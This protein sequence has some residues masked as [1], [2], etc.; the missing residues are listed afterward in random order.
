MPLNKDIHKVMVIGSGPIIIGQAAEFD[1]A[2]S[3]AC[4]ALKEQGLE[5]VLVNSNPATLMTDHTMADQIYIEPLIP[6][7]I[8]RIIEKEKPDSLL[9]TLGGQ[10]GLTLSMELAKSGFLEKH[11]VKLLG[12][13]PETI[14]KAEDRQMFKDTMLA[15]GEPCIPSKVVTTYEDALDFVKNEIGYPAII[16]PAFTLGGT[17]GGIVHNDEEMDEIAHNG[18]HRSPI[19][20]ILVEKCISGWKE[21]EFEVMRDSAGNVLTVCSMENF[22]PVG[23]HTGDSIVIAPTVTL[24]D[25]EY[26]MLRSAAL[27]IISSLG[28]EGGCNCQ[29][30]LNPNSFEY[31]VIEVN[32][33]VSRSS[34]LASK[35]TG[36]PIAKVATLIAI[37]YTLDEIPN[38]VT[39]KTAACFEPVLD[40]VV[41]KMPKFPFDKFVYA[42]RDLGTQMKATGEVMAIGQ[43]FEQ[44]IMKAVRGAEVG[45]QSLNLPSFVE[46]SDAEIEKRVGEC[47]DQRIFAIFQAIKRN[48]LSIIQIN[49]ITK[50]DLWFL[51]KLENLAFM[52]RDFAKVKAGEKEFTLEFYKAAKNAG[53]PDKVIQELA[54]QKITG[55]SGILSEAK[56]AA[57]L[58][59]QGK[60]AH[61]PAVYKMVDTCAGE[62]NAET[63]YFYG[64]Y[65]FQNEARIFLDERKE[66]GKKSSKGTIIVLG[67]GPIR[68]GQ[69]IEFDYAS[70]QC[71]WALK[72]LGYD[73]VTINNNPETVSTDF[74]TSDRL[75]FEPLTP[76]DVMGVI[77]TEKPVGVVVA[78]GG[79]TAIKLTKFLDSQGIHILGTSADS[80]DLAED[81]E[82]FEELCEK[83]H[84]NRPKGLTIFTEEEALEATQKLGYP[85]LLRPSYVLGGQNMII[86][87]NDDDVKEYMKIILAQGIENPVLIDQYMMGTELEVDAICDGKDILIPGIMEHIERTGIH[88]GD[89]IAVYPSWNLNDILREKIINQSR[90]LALA[91]G[92]KGLVNIQYLIYN[93]DL[94]IIEVNPRSSRTVPYISK[95]TNVPMV[96]LAVRAMLGEKVKDMGFGT[97]LYRLPPYFAVKVPVFSFEKLMDVDTHLG[98]EMKST[99]E[100]LGIASTMEEAI[101]KGLIG[102]GYN[103][104]RSGGV[105]FSVRKTDRY[106]LPDLA[107]K[108]YDMGFKLYATEGNAKTISD[109]GMEVE[110]VNKIHEN[111]NDNL[112]S[113]LDSGKVDYVISTSAKGRDPRA[114]SVR[115]R[116]HAVERDIPC[117]TAIDTAN[118]IANCLK[119]KYT[120]ENVELVDI[121]Q[122]REEKQKITFYK[123]DSTGNDFI[124]IN[125]MNQVVKNPA[126]LAVRLCDRRN[127]GI[128]ADS[129]V[130]IEESKIADAKMRFFNL[131]GTEGKMAGNAI[132]CVGKYLYDN[133]IKGIQEKHGKKTDATEK[134]TIE[135]GSGVKTLVLY[136][137]NGKVTSVTVD[138][139]KPLFAS[140]EIPTSL[141]AVDVPNCGL[142]E[143]IG[144]A[145]LPKKAVVNAPLI[146]AENEYRVTC[147]NVGN[148]H[149]VVFSKFVDKEPVAKIGPLFESHSVFPE[150]TNTE[151]VRVVGPNELKMRTWERGNGETLA[152]GTGACAAAVASVINGFSPINQDIT[153]KVR[154]GNLIVKYTGETVLLTGNTKM[155]YQGEVEI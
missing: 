77:N 101:F 116:R 68:I 127:G 106:E 104:K 124:V 3:Q 110:V 44:A 61:I 25:K 30:A 67:S 153:V 120:A 92:T 31:A 74:D 63:P 126:G 4:K 41:V 78:F 152:C 85:V 65:D 99:G 40:Y 131:D 142:N 54:G 11:G 62:F 151:F 90:E 18:L 103:M 118:A 53:Y 91:L 26:Q 105:L 129:L 146:V 109:F 144:N 137:Q 39:K 102:A 130:L 136:K 149:C 108:F 23:V 27:N 13:K 36:Y 154:G 56:E 50:I 155:C 60:V 134:I 57:K 94:Y 34:A 83:L 1:Y 98:P 6:E 111:P 33:R 86:A 139:G 75:Y 43:T 14:D 148:P 19:H 48:I 51:A 125:A 81:R 147:V 52:E 7:T 21:I 84:I 49:K 45:A 123:M 24:S 76:E 47:T 128:G 112:L 12:A 97:G 114:D 117:L 135:T 121:N 138:M 95:V 20:Q 82:R 10:T 80:I 69:G 89:S 87:F 5:V 122:L 96:D 17:G 55:A 145:V 42:K 100:V 37:G 28:M 9:S 132:R 133:N 73:V 46:M 140:E 22:D 88:S 35:A 141:V 64:T 38:A 8:Q 66:K 2:G 93:N 115:M 143:E 70:V 150:K 79:Q 107:K 59:K 15:I 58:V 16:R 113:L 119:S 72:R 32:P 71:V 29:F